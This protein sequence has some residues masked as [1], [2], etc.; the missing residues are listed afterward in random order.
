MLQKCMLRLERN[1]LLLLP[2]F[3]LSTLLLF[4]LITTHSTLVWVLLMS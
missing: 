2:F 3:T 4:L 1:L